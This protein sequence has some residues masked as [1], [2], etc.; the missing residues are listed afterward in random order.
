MKAPTPT[1]LSKW[2]DALPKGENT[3]AWCGK[4]GPSCYVQ[5]QHP[6][7][8]EGK[9]GKDGKPPARCTDCYNT[10]ALA[11]RAKRKAELAA[12]P[13]CEAPGCSRRGAWKS[14]GVLLCGAH[15]KAAKVGH[16]RAASAFGPF[17]LFASDW[18]D[19]GDILRWAMGK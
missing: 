12:E 16:A 11:S 17:A 10:Q 3:C 18:Y 7:W 9:E 14:G 13:R 8:A 19:S 2:Y 15:L 1:A 4:V 5:F 6:F